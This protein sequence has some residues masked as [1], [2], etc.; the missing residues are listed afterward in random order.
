ML[1]TGLLLHLSR[2][3]FVQSA[4]IQNLTALQTEIA[5]A[6]VKDPSGRGTWRLLYRYDL[7]VIARNADVDLLKAVSSPSVFACGLLST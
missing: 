7:L 4:P 1:F 3:G 2:A 5:P 6:W